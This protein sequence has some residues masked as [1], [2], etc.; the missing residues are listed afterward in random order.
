MGVQIIVLK[1]KK[2]YKGE[3]IADILCKKFK[4]TLKSIN[5]PNRI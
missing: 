5:C 1:N 4:K 3:K 2:N